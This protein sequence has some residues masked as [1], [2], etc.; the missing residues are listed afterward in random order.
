MSPHA[1]NV[2]RRL[3]AARQ[4]WWIF[5]LLST[6]ALAI[7]VSAG[8]LLLFLVLDANWRFS[9]GMLAGL[10]LVWLAVTGYA[11]WV[12]ARRLAWHDRSLE[13]TARRVECEFPELGTNLIN[14]VQLSEEGRHN[15]SPFR[16][17]AVKVAASQVERVAFDAAAK[18]ES[19]FKRLIYCMQTPRDLAESLFLLCLVA[20][21]VLFCKAAIPNLGSAANRLLAPWN[22]VP[23]IG[24][25]GRIDVKPGDAEVILGGSLQITATLENTPAAPLEACFFIQPEGEAET[26]IVGQVSNLSNVGQVSNLSKTDNRQVGNPSYTAAIPS[27]LKPLRY[28]VEIGDSQSEAY[29]V[30]V[31]DKPMVAEVG[32][33]YQFPKYLGRKDETF[34]L[35]TPDLDAP[36]YTVA[37]LRI[38][39]T[40]PVTK[41]FL[42]LNGKKYAGDVREEGNLLE[43]SIPLL[44]NGSYTIHLFARD[45]L[46]DDAPRVNRIQV[47]PDR[48][49]MVELLK[50]PRGT[51][52]APGDELAVMIR[53]GDD[54]GIGRMKL[55]MK[56]PAVSSNERAEGIEKR[57]EGFI[58]S[59]NAPEP[60]GDSSRQDKP[61]GSLDEAVK[62][63]KTWNDFKN[64]TAPVRQHRF[65][66]NPED[67]KNASTVL[68]RAVAADERSLDDWGLSLKPQEAASPWLEI[69]IVGAEEK[70]S[71]ALADMENLRGAVWKIFEKQVRA[72]TVAGGMAKT[73]QIAELAAVAGD[74]RT[75]Q[76]DIQ[77]STDELAKSLAPS[78]N[79]ERRTIKRVLGGLAFGEMLVAVKLSDE[80][81][82]WKDATGKE[83]LE[84]LLA[85]QDAIIDTLRKLLEASRRAEEKMLAEMEKRPGGNLPD[86]VRQKLEQARDKLQKFLERQKKI[87]EASENLAKTPTEDFTE[88]QEQTL[89]GL[90][91]AEDDWA[92]F[93]KELQTDLSKLPE[94]DFANASALK[95]AVE[96]QVELKMAADALTKK[97]VDIAVP[98]EQL[99]YERAE[100]LVTNIEKWLPDSPD[101]EKWSQEESLTDKDKEA[102]MAELPG[103]LEDMI[104]ELMEQEE[105]LFNEME[106]V[107]SSA[108]DSLDKGAGWDAMDGPI[109]NMS[110]KGVTGNR[111]PNTSEIGGRSG[112][113]RQGKSSGEFV[114]D[115]AVGKGGRNTPSRLTPDPVVKGQIKDHSKESVGGATGGGKESGQGGE[116]LEGPLPRSPGQRDLER[117]AGKQAAL[118]NKAEG[119]DLQFQVNNF[120][121]TDLK[122][123]I[124]TMSQVEMDLKAGRYQNALRQRP[125]LLEKMTNVKQYLS[126]EFQVRQDATANLPADIQKEILGSM[127]DPS[128]QGWEELN[129]KYFERLSK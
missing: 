46:T 59:P 37:R 77:K 43:A 63:V 99:G 61:A 110:A 124:E 48:P 26:V 9:Q 74:M 45:K 11:M 7:C 53:G 104:G 5:S 32:V 120:H 6:L 94:Q 91:A 40:R 129:R 57:A 115:E 107:S 121:Q 16:E 4:K 30:T 76:V 10:C 109:S 23:S 2:I 42:H 103:E 33:T 101:R 24:K 51:T 69:K 50:P 66:L 106:D 82:K 14:L 98:L 3:D 95:E 117:L 49:P 64:E 92:K 80:I 123:M 122:K 112:E 70:N 127:Q 39:P 67:I 29:R 73:G 84:K 38:R 93:M 55:E 18:K 78:E 20:A 1:E 21:A 35:K 31:S 86:D 118:R 97:S 89:K 126:G 8:L 28:R 88:E 114:G 85:T 108:A 111:L 60:P 116:G 25:A 22:F 113:G 81:A 36:Q 72:R 71:A 12:V 65:K 75:Q 27:I 128:P 90:A 100:E 47:A 34:E 83:S 102:P 13:A 58:P 15:D 119:L 44:Q 54:Y 17:A 62:T 41:G 56:V 96:V 52:A 19:R 125:V 87:I 79:E 105:D 68:L